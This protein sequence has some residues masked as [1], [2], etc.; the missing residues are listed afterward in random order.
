MG[1]PKNPHVLDRN[2]C[3]SSSGSAVAVAAGMVPLAIGTETHGSIVC[4]A[5]VNGIVGVKPSLGLVSRDGIIP[6]AESQDTAGPMTRNITDAARALQVMAV[7]DPS[8]QRAQGHPGQVD[9]LSGLSVD[10]LQGKRIGVW[11]S[12]TGAGQT[13]RV[14]QIYTTTL[15]ALQAQGAELIDPIG[16]YL[17]RGRIR[18]V[19]PDHVVRI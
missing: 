5:G 19:L 13:P 8:D 15:A 1:K 4:P 2:P 14:T 9:M 18:G 11:R 16:L 10:G 12:Y 3:G 6:I 17:D 7:P